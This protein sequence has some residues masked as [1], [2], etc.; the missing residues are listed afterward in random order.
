[1]VLVQMVKDDLCLGLLQIPPWQAAPW[2]Y[3]HFPAKNMRKLM[4]KKDIC[5]HVFGKFDIFEVLNINS[6]NPSSDCG[7][8]N[9]FEAIS[10]PYLGPILANFPRLHQ[11]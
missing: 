4:D 1:V 5:G 11:I 8:E 2:L 3:A 6:G 10:S 7:I 9:K